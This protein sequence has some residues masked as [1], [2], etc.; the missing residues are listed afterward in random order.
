MEIPGDCQCVCC[1]N[2]WRYASSVSPRRGR[3]IL[4]SRDCPGMSVGPQRM[5]GGVYKPG[6]GT[7]RRGEAN[8]AQIVGAFPIPVFS[9]Q[10]RSCRREVLAVVP[11]RWR[12]RWGSKRRGAG[13]AGVKERQGADGT[14]KKRKQG[15]A[16]ARSGTRLYE[17][18]KMKF[19]N[20]ASRKER[21]K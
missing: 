9:P 11:G 6:V 7:A 20:E 15:R 14:S 18:E 4:N 5:E 16:E 1:S 17:S 3:R 8:S 19:S 13:T 2:A 21:G 10:R 12:W